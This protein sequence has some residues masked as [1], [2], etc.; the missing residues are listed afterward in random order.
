MCGK[1]GGS[2]DMCLP[3]K[4]KA[5]G[6][7][8]QNNIGFTAAEQA[9]ILKFHNEYRR[10]IAKGLETG[11]KVTIPPAA[12]MRALKWNDNLATVAQRWA[13]QCE[14]KHDKMSNRLAPP[15][16]TVGQN[17]FIAMSSKDTDEVPTKR[18]ID[19]WYSEVKD[20][21]SDVGSFSFT[22]ETGHF[23]QLI[24]GDTAEVLTFC[25]SGNKQRN[26]KYSCTSDEVSFFYVV[27]SVLTGPSGELSMSCFRK[28]IVNILYL[29]ENY[30]EA[31]QLLGITV[32]C[33]YT[34]WLD[35]ADYTKMVVCNYGESGNWKGEPMYKQGDP[36]SK[37]PSGTNCDDGICA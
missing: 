22:H 30:C 36:C 10:K 16:D 20:F 25:V 7:N 21:A 37:C 2:H 19:G 3:E 35:G 31:F 12:N 18:G 4:G 6:D 17:I 27:L 8:A 13:D 29:E 32:G 23:T 28:P 5:C 15:F 9:D 11:A 34:K 33:G 14:F 26:M 24:W 1:Y